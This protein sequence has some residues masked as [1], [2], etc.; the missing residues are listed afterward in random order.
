MTKKLNRNIKYFIIDDN[1]DYEHI[2]KYDNHIDIVDKIKSIDVIIDS[3][4][5]YIYLGSETYN[6]RLLKNGHKA[7][8]KLI[9]KKNKIYSIDNNYPMNAFCIDE[10]GD[11]Y[12]IMNIWHDFCLFSSNKKQLE[13]KI[14][15]KTI[16]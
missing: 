10:T 8:K 9:L 1:C 4:E 15:Y 11:E 2:I 16:L 13:R 14:K 7:I 6:N 12:D 5:Y 3:G